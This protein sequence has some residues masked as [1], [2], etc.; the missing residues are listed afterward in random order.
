[1][2]DKQRLRQ[3]QQIEVDILDE[4]DRI[5]RINNIRYCLVGGTLLGAVR[6]QGFI[7][8]DDDLD[9]AMPRS[10]YEK[11][12]NV[13]KSQ[14]SADYY[15]HSVDSDPTYWLPFIKVRK[16]YTIF[17]EKNTAGLGCQTGIYVDI[18]PLDDAKDVDSIS[19][20]IITKLIKEISTLYLYKI[21]FYKKHDCRVMRRALYSI[22]SVISTR[23]LQKQQTRL[24]KHY[25]CKS[26]E[27]YV[28]YG[29]NYDPKK[30]TMPKKV[31][32]PFA[33]VL[34]EGKSYYAP[35]DT[36]YYLRRLYGNNY[37][38]LPPVEKRITHD[39]VNLVFDT[40]ENA[41]KDNQ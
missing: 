16:K 9:I 14:T 23:T 22:L 29:S 38:E 35:N 25:N 21:G 8:W 15:I 41:E 30:Q 3:L 2:V 4:I 40:R 6:H 34:F 10:D 13:C 28:N 32:E 31:Y 12:I 18:F 37:M 5:C 24:M 33:E 7:P 26:A 1:M 17:E 20:R 36:D 27:Y 11:F 39:P 19:K